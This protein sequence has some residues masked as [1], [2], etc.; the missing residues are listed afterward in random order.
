MCREGKQ[1]SPLLILAARGPSA[2]VHT[3]MR[4]VCI[5]H[6]QSSEKDLSDRPGSCVETSWLWEQ[7]DVIIYERPAGQQEVL[8]FRPKCNAV[9]GYVL[10]AYQ[11]SL[12]ADSN[13]KT[14]SST[15]PG[16]K[17][18]PSRFSVCY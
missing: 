18:S 9:F 13:R 5:V 17:G 8:W 15:R 14:F 1:V 4:W 16:F 10:L 3:A 7:Q 6:R 12:T 2:P 11:A